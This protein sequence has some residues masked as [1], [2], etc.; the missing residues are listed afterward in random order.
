MSGI[1]DLMRELIC[2]VAIT[3]LLIPSL[4]SYS[5][6]RLLPQVYYNHHCHCR[7]RCGMLN[8]AF[9]LAGPILELPKQPT[10]SR[11][12][13]WGAPTS[14]KW[15]IPWH[16]DHDFSST[17]HPSKFFSLRSQDENLDFFAISLGL[18]NYHLIWSY[19]FQFNQIYLTDHLNP[20][21]NHHCYAR[22]FWN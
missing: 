1:H 15:L 14:L 17:L 12:V 8:F 20:N 16:W 13:T 7:H 4:L 21:Q 19:L 9:F 10:I 5:R 3:L 2:S 18:M 6:L 22:F 11:L